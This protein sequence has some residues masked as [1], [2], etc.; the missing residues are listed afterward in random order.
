[1]IAL[2]NHEANVSMHVPLRAGF[3]NFCTGQQTKIQAATV[4]IVY[5]TMMAMKAHVQI[6]KRRVGK[7][8]L[9]CIKMASL[10][11]PIEAQYVLMLI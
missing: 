8:R 4:A 2:E 9:Y 6:W 3:Q 5:P 1:M 7:T 10:V 11:R